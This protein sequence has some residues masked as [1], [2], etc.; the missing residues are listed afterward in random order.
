MDSAI[1]RVPSGFPY[2]IVDFHVYGGFGEYIIA[3]EDRPGGHQ[4]SNRPVAN[5]TNA[6]PLPR[7]GASSSCSKTWAQPWAQ[8]PPEC[9]AIP[10]SIVQG[11]G[12]RTN[13]IAF[14][15]QSAGCRFES[16]PVH[17]LRN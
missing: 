16:Y 5:G 15:E 1:R 13:Y 8:N 17:H 12:R 6:L 3:K 4:A 9:R 7:M 11:S 14:L 2:W 10:W